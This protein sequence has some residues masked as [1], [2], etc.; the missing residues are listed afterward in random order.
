[1]YHKHDQS[2][3]GVD[4]GYAQM[5]DMGS[6]HDSDFHTFYCL[7]NTPYDGM[8]V[9]ILEM[10]EICNSPLI[11]SYEAKFYLCQFCL[12][13]TLLKT[14]KG[15]GHRFFES[16]ALEYVDSKQIEYKILKYEH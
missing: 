2:N 1:M 14:I 12:L 15:A 8:T 13:F 3:F 9:A 16:I 6:H 7:N 4:S 10:V 5:I 11:L